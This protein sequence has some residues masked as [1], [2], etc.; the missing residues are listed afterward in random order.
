MPRACNTTCCRCG[1][2]FSRF[3]GKL[4]NISDEGLKDF[5]SLPF[6][7]EYLKDPS[8]K[9]PTLCANCLTTLLG[10]KLKVKDIKFKQGRWMTSN[11]AYLIM[12]S[13]NTDEHKAQ[14]IERLKTYDNKGVLPFKNEASDT[15]KMY[16]ELLHV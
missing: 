11:V 16:R 14:L 5:Y 7:Q 6:I 8:H 1:D 2:A 3:S 10:R 9:H 12:S 13:N 4:I 15:L